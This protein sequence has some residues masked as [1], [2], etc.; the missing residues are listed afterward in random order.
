MRNRNT[1]RGEGKVGCIVSILIFGLLIAA[2]IRVVPILFSNNDFTN[3]I[4]NIA[5]RAGILPQATIELQLREKARELGIP[6]ALAAGAIVVTKAGDHMQGTCTV[7]VRYTRKIDFYGL[8]AYPLET[9]TTRNVL[10]MDA[11]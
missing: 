5:A 11:R 9:N 4:D 10:Y 1:Q 2:A 6:E 7:K 8:Y 3:S